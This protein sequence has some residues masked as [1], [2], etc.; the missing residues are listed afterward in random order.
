M[1][2]QFLAWQVQKEMQQYCA[3]DQKVKSEMCQSACKDAS[4]KD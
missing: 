3:C 1:N 2:K 4:N